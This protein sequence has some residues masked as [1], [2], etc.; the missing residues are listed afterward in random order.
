MVRSV[1]HLQKL[2]TKLH[3][4]NQE[5]QKRALRKRSRSQLVAAAPVELARNNLARKTRTRG[6]SRRRKIQVGMKKLIT[7]KEGW[8]WYSRRPIRQCRYDVQP[9]H[10]RGDDDGFR[11]MNPFSGVS[12]LR[13]LVCGGKPD[14]KQLEVCEVESN[15]AVNEAHEHVG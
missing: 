5:R 6:R 7:R 15:G 2:K 1:E 8:I 9:H 13:F 12:L 11:F 4:R 14:S 10:S 3:Q